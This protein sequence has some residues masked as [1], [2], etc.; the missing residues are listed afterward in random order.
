MAGRLNFSVLALG[1]LTGL[2]SAPASAQP[3][4]ADP[5]QPPVNYAP[6]NA[7]TGA[8]EAAG[9]VSGPVLDSV[10]LPKNGRPLAVISGQPV[11]LGEY[12][13]E[14]RLIRVTEHEVV[15]EGATGTEHLFLTPGIE[16]TAVN[17][18][19]AGTGNRTQ[20]TQASQR[21]HTAGSGSKP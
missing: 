1:L 15:L 9:A 17:K 2:T 6:E 7:A 19:P 5:T 14:S 12:F 11:Y 16:K 21:A 18:T 20:R 3:L 8:A 4:P 10:L 13:G